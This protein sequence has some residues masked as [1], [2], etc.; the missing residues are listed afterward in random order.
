MILKMIDIGAIIVS[1]YIEKQKQVI[2][3]LEPWAQC[4]QK[5]IKEKLH[6]I[7]KKWNGIKN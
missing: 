5:Q 4:I 1:K 3:L 2:N 7:T 6:G